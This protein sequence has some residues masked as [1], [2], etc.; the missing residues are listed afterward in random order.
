MIF[1]FDLIF[2]F[3]SKRLFITL[4]I[5]I[6][7]CEKENL[8]RET[9][10]NRPKNLVIAVSITSRITLANMKSGHAMSFTPIAEQANAFIR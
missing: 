9:E 6:N 1:A 8:T 2:K 3:W 7:V 5:T 4:T 10:I